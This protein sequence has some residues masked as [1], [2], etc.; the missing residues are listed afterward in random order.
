MKIK[1]SVGLRLKL[2]EFVEQEG[3]CVAR[4][5]MFR[6]FRNELSL[7]EK[8]QKLVGLNAEQKD[9]KMMVFV[10]KPDKDPMKEF[11]IGEI[12]TEVICSK[13]KQ[14]DDQKAMTPDLLDLYE[15]FEDEIKK[16]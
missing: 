9:G 13:F 14:L 3:D 10:T 16:L 7:T 4:L 2:S 12:I 1:L 8:E 6:D 11:K 5:K 15:K